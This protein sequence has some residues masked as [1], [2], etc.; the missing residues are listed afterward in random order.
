[1]TKVYHFKDNI[2]NIPYEKLLKMENVLRDKVFVNSVLGNGSRIA[3]VVMAGDISMVAGNLHSKNYVAGSAG[4]KIDYNGD[5]EFESG[6]FRGDISGAT[7]AFTSGISIGTSPDW[8]KVDADG[9]C[10][11][12]QDTLANAQA[13]TF[14]V[15][16][17][18]VAYMRNIVISGLAAGSA[19]D[20]QYATNVTAVALSALSANLGTITAGNITLDSSGFIRMGATTYRDVGIWQ[21]Y[22]TTT[23]KQ[24][25][26]GTSG[27]EF[28]FDG[29][30]IY[31]ND[32]N[33]SF[34]SFWGDGSDGTVDIN[35][36]AFTSGPITSNALTRDAYFT[37]L[38]LS[39]GDLNCAGYRLFV[40][41]TLTINNG[42]KVHRNGNNGGN[43]ANG[44]YGGQD[45]PI[46][47]GTGGAQLADAFLSGGEDGKAGGEGGRGKESGAG[48]P[49]GGTVAG[50]AVSNALGAN[51][52][53]G[54]NGGRGGRSI[55]WAAVAAAGIGGAGGVA[56]AS[57]VNPKTYT[58]LVLMRNFY[59]TTPTKFTIN[60]G[61]GGSGGGGAGNKDS[62]GPGEYKGGGSGGGGGGG[63]SSA[64][65]VVILAKKIINNGIISANGGNGGNGGN[66]ASAVYFSL[67][68]VL[69]GCGGGGGAG[70][71]GNGGL[72][73][74]IYNSLSGS[75]SITVSGGTAGTAGI[76]GTPTAEYP[77]YIGVNGGAGTAG[78]TG[79]IIQLQI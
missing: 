16:N 30:N 71:G 18:G 50:D 57:T 38:T 27:D 34:Q 13:N 40:K 2:E 64:G 72:V 63:G 76:A 73:V 37:N 65:I 26:K 61:T 22:D 78:A 45:L 25:I 51:G 74:A 68:N 36:G 28:Y 47:G 24:S 1:M 33:L 19:V 11:L 43:G 23:Y 42:Y 3:N 59:D 75:G 31:Y 17:A 77:A 46:P 49:T 67:Y 39:G 54:A 15:T 6:Y 12:G 5:V 55:V 9:N 56:T 4:W 20:L 60:G 14:A 8:F 44:G 79:I 10:W 48:C 52:K 62:G 53:A 32:S 70:S 58:E 7:G 41:G 69:I 66:G 21:G 35:S 29:V